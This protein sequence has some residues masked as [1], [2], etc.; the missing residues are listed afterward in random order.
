[1]F[2]NVRKS[3]ALFMLAGFVFALA[4]TIISARLGGGDHIGAWIFTIALCGGAWFTFGWLVLDALTRVEGWDN[5]GGAYSREMR[6]YGAD[7]RVVVAHQY[8]DC[9]T[10]T[11]WHGSVDPFDYDGSE[12][13]ELVAGYESYGVLVDV[14]SDATDQ[15]VASAYYGVNDL[16]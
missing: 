7:V 16:F 14:L 15:A 11:I 9:Y 10:V 3:D 8:A 5:A 6:V 1:M 12:S 13:W 4:V 2:H